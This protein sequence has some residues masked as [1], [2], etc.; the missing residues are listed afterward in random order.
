[1]R[2]GGGGAYR[3][4]QLRDFDT[5]RNPAL[6]TA[7]VREVRPTARCHTLHPRLD[8]SAR[9]RLVSTGLDRR[10]PA[11]GQQAAAAPL[12]GGR[13]PPSCRRAGGRHAAGQAARVGK[14]RRVAGAAARLPPL[15][16]GALA[17]GAVRQRARAAGCPSALPP[18][19]EERARED[20]RGTEA[21]RRVGGAAHRHAHPHAAR[22]REPRPRPLLQNAPSRSLLLEPSWSSPVGLDLSFVT[23]L[24]LVNP[25]DD[26]VAQVRRRGRPR[27][28]PRFTPRSP[29]M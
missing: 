24:F 16:A 19:A 13:R 26:E 10:G 8:V 21:R 14:V 2:E 25:I 18:R 27:W 29:E 4:W 1:M 3:R 12:A 5:Y 23:H 22:G 11:R 28:A 17:A 6:L 20:P 15:L 9:P 7:A